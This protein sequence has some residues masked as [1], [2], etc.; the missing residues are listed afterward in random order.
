MYFSWIVR[1][2]FSDFAGCTGESVAMHISNKDINAI[3]NT[4]S[5]D[6]FEGLRVALGP[7]GQKESNPS[8]PIMQSMSILP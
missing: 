2:H 5:F 8:L 4:G 3:S 6:R 7:K 1:P